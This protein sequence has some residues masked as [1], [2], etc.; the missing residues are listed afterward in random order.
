MIG[1]RT[2]MCDGSGREYWE[3]R[4]PSVRPWPT[5]GPMRMEDPPISA[6]TIPSYN[7]DGSIATNSLSPQHD[8]DYTTNGA[9]SGGSAGFK[10]GISLCRETR[11]MRL[12]GLTSM[13][14][15]RSKHDHGAYMSGTR[16]PF[17]ATTAK[18]TVLSMSYD[19]IAPRA[20]W[21]VIRA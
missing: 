15:V 11:T 16:S 5:L 2:A 3:L 8:L 7:F 17:R 6:T 12:R 13:T 14:A 20:T 21:D 4:Q 1:H 9:S 18:N 10:F 19:S